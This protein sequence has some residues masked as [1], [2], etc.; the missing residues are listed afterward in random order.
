MGY[1]TVIKRVNKLLVLQEQINIAMAQESFATEIGKLMQFREDIIDSI[2][3]VKNT[4]H[5]V[6]EKVDKVIIQTTL[7]NGRVNALEKFKN[8]IIKGFWKTFFIFLAGAATCFFT[9][10]GFY[11]VNHLHK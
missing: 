9:L 2:V 10:L 8:D 6:S 4:V 1:N 3:D 7:T 11:I 5:N